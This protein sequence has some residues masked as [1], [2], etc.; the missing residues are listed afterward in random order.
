MNITAKIHKVT[1]NIVFSANGKSC[2][3]VRKFVDY[4]VLKCIE[5]KKYFKALNAYKH[6]ILGYLDDD[7]EG[8]EYYYN[9][10]KEIHPVYMEL[11]CIEDWEL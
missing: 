7:F 6:N 11:L 5:D 4:I 3:L 9:H 1:N 10:L 2:I 8:L